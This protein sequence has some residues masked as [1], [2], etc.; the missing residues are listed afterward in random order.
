MVSATLF[1]DKISY[2]KISPCE[3]YR[4]VL[5]RRWD[6]GPALHFVML[7][8]STADAEVDDQTI[9]KCVGFAKH[10][11]YAAIEVRNLFAWRATDPQEISSGLSFSFVAVGAMN[12]SHLKEIPLDAD[13]VCAWGGNPYK[14]N[15]G[16][17]RVAEVL[18]LLKPRNLFCVR[19]TGS[20]PW[21][22]LYVSYG[23]LEKFDG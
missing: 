23:A 6:D 12:D 9:R 21:H 1:E 10:N 3:H 20:Q 17:R 14:S 2:A 19:R 4:Y 8:P 15:P 5:G 22:P 13:V 11:G 7:N 16:A 18:T